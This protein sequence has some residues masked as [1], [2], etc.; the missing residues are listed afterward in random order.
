MSIES[1]ELMDP[2]FS[3]RGGLGRARQLFGDDLDAL[4]V[5]LTDVVAA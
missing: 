2:P 1:R 3:G 5:E 4:L